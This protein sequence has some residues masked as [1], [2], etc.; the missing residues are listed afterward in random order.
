MQIRKE[1]THGLI[2]KENVD[3]GQGPHHGLLEDGDE[4]RSG[5]VH[6]EGLVVRSCMLPQRHDRVGR[7]GQHEALQGHNC[8]ETV[9]WQTGISLAVLRYC[10]SL[11][12]LQQITKHSQRRS[13]IEQLRRQTNTSFPDGPL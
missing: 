2:A 6:H 13:S 11:Y 4:E 5:Q 8:T 1:P 7:H 9:A 10:P 3:E 12:L